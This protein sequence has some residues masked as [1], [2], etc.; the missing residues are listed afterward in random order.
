MA[1]QLDDESPAPPLLDPDSA[2]QHHNY[3]LIDQGDCGDCAFRAICD[4]MWWNDEPAAGATFSLEDAKKKGAWLRAQTINHLRKHKAE[5]LPFFYQHYRGK[6]F[7]DWR[8]QA[9]ESEYWVNG[10]LLQG[11]ANKLGAALII[12]RKADKGSWQRF[13]VAP[14]FN[15]A[16]YA[17]A[18]QGVAPIV[19]TL[20]QMHYKSLRVPR[21]AEVPDAW[22]REGCDVWKSN[23]EGGGIHKEQTHSPATSKGTPS[24]HSLVHAS[25]HGLNPAQSISSRSVRT[26]SVHSVFGPA[27]P[28]AGPA[29]SSCA[30]LPRLRRSGLPLLVVLP[31]CLPCRISPP[32][33]IPWCVAPA[34]PQSSERWC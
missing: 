9:S 18:A 34:N 10:M 30:L 15:A 13:C 8:V 17:C 4:S 31:P 3:S 6:T 22:L 14:R 25:G 5:L 7:D 28:A 1:T 19:L 26:P 12:F 2:M 11:V 32:R 24:V 27:R 21:G 16:G 20:E 33:C 29:E 23:L